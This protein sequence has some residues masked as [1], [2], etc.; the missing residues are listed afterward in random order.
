MAPFPDPHHPRTLGCEFVSSLNQRSAEGLSVPHRSNA[1]APRLCVVGTCDHM[2]PEKPSNGRYWPSHELSFCHLPTNVRSTRWPPTRCV[3]CTPTARALAAHQWGRVRGT[4]PCPVKRS[5][6]STL[7]RIGLCCCPTPAP[8]RGAMGGAEPAE[9]PVF[10]MP[11]PCHLLGEGRMP[12]GNAEESWA[13][14]GM[15][16]WPQGD[17]QARQTGMAA[18]LA[19]PCGLPHGKWCCRAGL[20]SIN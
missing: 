8:V 16:A 7:H 18:R 11:R 19:H 4:S 13:E 9:V 15:R 14:A 12:R 6:I 20:E 5:F 3:M 10:P 1:P 17:S 2:T